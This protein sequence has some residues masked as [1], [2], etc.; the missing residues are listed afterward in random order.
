MILPGSASQSLAAALADQLDEPLAVV[1]TEHFAD[2]EFKLRVP[3][4]GGD[5]AIIVAATTSA[6]AHLELLQLQDLAREAFDEVVTVLPYMGYA[7]QDKSFRDGEPVSARAVA[8]ALSASTDRVVAV[9]PHEPAIG[10]FFDV[11]FDVVD[12]APRL[13][14]P[15]P[16]L[17]DPL[18]LAPDEGAIGLAETVCDAYGDGS[19]DYFEK[20]RSYDTGDVTV[21]PSG[22][23]PAGRTVVL[24]DDIVATGSTM[25]AAVGQLHERNVGE[26][27]VTC[28]HPMFAANARSKLADAGVAG[29]W[30]TDTIERPASA[31]SVAP[32]LADY[33]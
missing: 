2:G 12:A 22:T 27:Y 19:T 16:D 18:F 25:S 28:L 4:A 1:E 11:P 8:R 5:L 31:V 24:V 21:E 20:T 32:T 15:L 33:F 9:N 29:V 26:V 10:D 13:A 14:E 3:A 23:E 7:R 17:D 30:G 6:E